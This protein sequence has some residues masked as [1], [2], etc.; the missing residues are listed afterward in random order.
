M[1]LWNGFRDALDTTVV[2]SALSEASQQREQPAYQSAALRK[3]ML[4]RYQ[5]MSHPRVPLSFAPTPNT[6]ILSLMLYSTVVD[7]GGLSHLPRGTQLLMA[8]TCIPY[9]APE[10]VCTMK[11]GLSPFMVWEHHQRYYLIKRCV[12]LSRYHIDMQLHTSTSN[13]HW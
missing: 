1:N 6:A 12:W 13:A 7:N 10:G 4:R 9:I 5:A 3:T 11:W 8:A 2:R